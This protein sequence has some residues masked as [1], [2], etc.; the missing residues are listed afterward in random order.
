LIFSPDGRFLAAIPVPYDYNGDVEVTSRTA[1]VW[2][3]PT[4]RE[5]ARM[6]HPEGIQEIAFSSDGR[7]LAAA[8]S[9]PYAPATQKDFHVSIWD[10]T[11][12]KEVQVFSGLPST[13]QVRFAN[14]NKN[15]VISSFGSAQ[16]WVLSTKQLQHS[17]SGNRAHISDDGRKVT[18]LLEK[19][20][21]LW[22]VLTGQDLQHTPLVDSAKAVFFDPNGRLVAIKISRSDSYQIWNVENGR[23]VSQI[24]TGPNVT[25]VAFSPGSQYLISQSVEFIAHV[26][27]IA[28]GKNM[29]LIDPEDMIDPT[30]NTSSRST[31]SLSSVLGFSQD[32][33]LV[34]VAGL[35]SMAGKVQIWKITKSDNGESLAVRLDNNIKSMAFSPNGKLLATISWAVEPYESRDI[36]IWEISS[37]HEVAHMS[38]EQG[39]GVIAFSP[40]N[41]FL[42]SGGVDQTVRLWDVTTGREVKRFGPAGP[43]T[44]LLFTPDGRYIGTVGGDVMG[45]GFRHTDKTARLWDVKTGQEVMVLADNATDMAI[46]DDGNYVAT[47]SEN[48]AVRVTDIAGD[49]TALELEHEGVR[50]VAMSKDGRYLATGAMDGSIYL[51]EVST[52]KRLLNLGDAGTSVDS[53]TLSSDG[54]YLGAIAGFSA[55]QTENSVQV[56]RVWDTTSGRVILNIQPGI[57]ALVFSPD[58]AYI[59][60]AGPNGLAHVWEVATGVE[61][62]RIAHDDFTSDVAFSPDGLYLATIGGSAGR[63]WLWRPQDLIDEACSRLTRNLTQDEWKHYLPTETYHKTCPNLP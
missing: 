33:S 63:L 3:I 2:E 25:S 35:E 34:A 14:D 45:D 28:T 48:G 57:K 10:I 62:S 18:V 55:V 58:G 26:W 6:I 51:W 20:I 12:G 38:H 7:L 47:V 24:D 13:Q 8:G 54:R 53:L 37:G 9:D 21:V 23:M 15:I 44:R 27:D 16:S 11:S 41:K 17:F 5:I 22:D 49:H 56:N 19:E 4:G 42:A 31:S 36:H 43:V 59:G 40:D 30:G 61:W 50:S 52:K 32:E 60:T 29:A 46:S 39:A 1:Y